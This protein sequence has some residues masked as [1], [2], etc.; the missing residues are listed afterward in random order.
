M[1]RLILFL[2][3]STVLLSCNNDNF[4]IVAVKN[5]VSDFES[6]NDSWTGAM[7][8]YTIAQNPTDTNFVKLRRAN[9]PTGLDTVHYG[10]TLTSINQGDNTFT[11]LKKQVTGLNPGLTYNV[12]YDIRLG[13]NIIK[14]S[15][16][17]STT[18]LKVGAAPIEPVTNSTTYAFNLDKG[19][20]GTGGKQ[21]VLAGS[22]S[23]DLARNSY[24]IVQRTNETS[25]QVRADA[26]GSIWLCVG[27][28]S[29]YKG[30]IFFYFD[31]IT[32]TITEN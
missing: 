1:L 15:T 20:G 12:K 31:K 17:A 6:A 24:V 18:Y 25:V 29:G 32:A 9:L 13:S 26:S 5:V 27:I 21:M 7:A 16:L 22:I 4:S 11:Y 19:K 3:V 14:N 8:E 28:D 30:T 23:N 2:G 10:L